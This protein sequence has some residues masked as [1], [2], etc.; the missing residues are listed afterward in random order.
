MIQQIL[1][2]WSSGKDSA[3]ALYEI[4][5]DPRFEVASLLTT[6]TKDYDRISMHGVRRQLLEQQ[7]DSLGLPLEKVFITA[8]STDEDYRSKMREVLERYKSGGTR[9]VA[10]GDLYLEDV[11]QY[12]QRNLAEVGMK[13]IF[14]LWGKDTATLARRI[15][16]LGFKS[17]VTCVDTQVLDGKFAGR[18][19]DNEFLAELPQGIDPCGENGEFH[20]FT[21][22]GPIFDYPIEHKLGEVV[23]RDNRFCFCDVIPE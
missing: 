3:F 18:S 21:W 13:A 22:D 11:R 10:F 15:I 4:L 12:R 14:P 5:N 6:V 23:L 9:S 2:C 20:S 7:A 8:G 17:V 1:F 19:F 16:D